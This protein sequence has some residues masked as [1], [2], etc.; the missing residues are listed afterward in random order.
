MDDCVSIKNNGV[1]AG[2]TQA[3]DD[4]GE[5]QDLFINFFGEKS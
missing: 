1:V 4:A 3:G 5:N 2:R